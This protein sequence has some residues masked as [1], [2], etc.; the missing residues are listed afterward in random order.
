MSARNVG[1]KA[2]PTVE[3]LEFIYERLPRLSDGEILEEMQGTEFPLRSTGFIKRR[4]KEFDTAKRVLQVQLQKEVAPLLL[5]R[6]EEHFSKL[7]E[8]VDDLLAN[9]LNSVSRGWSTTRVAGQHTN[10]LTKEKRIG[11]YY[12]LTNE[13][14]ST[15]LKENYVLAEHKYERWFIHDCLLPHLKS[16]FPEELK[17]KAFLDIAK[18]HPYEL[19]QILRI[20]AAKKTFK[21]T[22]PA[23]P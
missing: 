11:D 14:L 9:D 12:D 6:R 2:E 1:K 22:C 13:Q 10:I 23:C 8:V 21:G 5:K 7:A 15:R 20:I 19:I 4:R 16:E 17:S 3:E 18:E